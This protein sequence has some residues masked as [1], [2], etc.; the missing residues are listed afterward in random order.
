MKDNEPCCGDCM[1][2]G[3]WV[4]LCLAS[5]CMHESEGDQGDD[6]QEKQPSSD[7]YDDL[8]DRVR[9]VR[10]VRMRRAGQRRGG[11]PSHIEAS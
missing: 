11:E 3:L 7:S 9:P 10:G 5:P 6:K 8:L 4:G 1:P 2:G